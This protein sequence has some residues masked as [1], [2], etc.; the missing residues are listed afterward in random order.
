MKPIIQ[1]I[2]INDPQGRVGNCLQAAVSSICQMALHE[3]PHFAAMPD[4]T[5]FEAMCNWL[6]NKGYDFEDFHS[7][8]DSPDFMLVIGPS[9]RGISHAVV[10]KDGKLAHDPHPSGE[11]I[12]SVKWCASITKKVVHQLT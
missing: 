11:G 8:N 5:W 1:D 7:V 9:P 12:L 2:F 4:D 3:V 6:Y 10:Y